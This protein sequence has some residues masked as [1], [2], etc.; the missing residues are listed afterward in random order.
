MN[1]STTAGAPAPL[2]GARFLLGAFAVSLATFMTVLDSSIA[3]VSIP[4]LSGDLVG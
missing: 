2:T 1:P 4:T 3:N